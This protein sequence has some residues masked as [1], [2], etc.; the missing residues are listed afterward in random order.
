VGGVIVRTYAEE[1]IALC[2]V[3]RMCGG[4]E[5]CGVCV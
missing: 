2:G 3:C 1:E 4:C 5:G